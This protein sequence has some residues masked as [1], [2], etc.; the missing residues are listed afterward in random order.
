MRGIAFLPMILATWA[1]PAVAQTP[2]PTP[3][4]MVERFMATQPD[5]NLAMYETLPGEFGPDYLARLNPRKA[6]EIRAIYAA[7]EA[8][9]APA[10]RAHTDRLLRL[11]ARRIGADKLMRLIAFQAS[12]DRAILADVEANQGEW[13]AREMAERQRI[14]DAYPLAEFGNLFREGVAGPGGEEYVRIL[15]SCQRIERDALARLRLRRR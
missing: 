7:G 8:C 3:E 5:P 9:S 10:S 14:Y 13:S 15:E 1:W 2:P 4:A 12:P 11:A 6:T